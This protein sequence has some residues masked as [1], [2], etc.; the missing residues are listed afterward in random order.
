[1]N[2]LEQQIHLFLQG[3]GIEAFDKQYDNLKQAIQSF[4]QQQA[5]DKHLIFKRSILYFYQKDQIINSIPYTSEDDNVY[6]FDGVKVSRVKPEYYLGKASSMVA[7]ASVLDGL[8]ISYSNN[9]NNN[10]NNN[11][12]NNNG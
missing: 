5:D 8:E 1:M 4:F 6:T 7:G 11:N 12:G 10:N 3:I 2:Q 9:N